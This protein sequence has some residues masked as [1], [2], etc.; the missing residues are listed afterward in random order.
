MYSTCTSISKIF[1]VNSTFFLLS[2]SADNIE[3]CKQT[4]KITTVSPPKLGLNLNHNFYWLLCVM[5]AIEGI[6]GA[7]SVY[8]CT[9]MSKLEKIK[10]HSLAGQSDTGA[11][12][13]H[14]RG[15][16]YNLKLDVKPSR[17]ITARLRMWYV[18]FLLPCI[19]DTVHHRQLC[20]NIDCT[21]WIALRSMWWWWCDDTNSAS[22][23]V[24]EMKSKCYTTSHVVV[25]FTVEQRL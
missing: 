22:R 4:F 21:Q 17:Y 13:T 20:L 24:V 1:E 5:N 8:W 9:M 25:Q 23:R 16:R 14:T 10:I 18:I 12:D 7:F 19:C 2:T 11:G 15:I 6:S 3:Y